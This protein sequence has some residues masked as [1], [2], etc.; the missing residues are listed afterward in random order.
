MTLF[1]AE[2]AIA[3]DWLRV[4]QRLHQPVLPTVASTAAPAPLPQPAPASGGVQI[5][6]MSGA[7]PGGRASITARTTAGAACSITYRTPAGTSSTAQGLTA[8]TADSSGGVAW[9]WSIGPSTPSGAGSVVV[10][11]DGASDRAPIQIG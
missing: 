4:Y 7:A 10:T 1:D 9:T 6:S 2:H 11:C 5:I 8:R 3:T